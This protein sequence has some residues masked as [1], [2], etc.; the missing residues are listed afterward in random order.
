MVLTI[1]IQKNIQQHIFFSLWPILTLDDLSLLFQNFWSFS[2]LINCYGELKFLCKFSAFSTSSISRTFVDRNIFSK[3][4]T[5]N[6]KLHNRNSLGRLW[7]GESSGQKH[8]LFS[9]VS[10]YV[11]I[12]SSSFTTRGDN[13][14]GCF[15]PA[16]LLMLFLQ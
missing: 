2:V 3:Q 15:P 7:S 10:I 14:C 11:T 5:S 1:Q 6:P 13:Y 12:V 16:C 4:S 8:C 9:V